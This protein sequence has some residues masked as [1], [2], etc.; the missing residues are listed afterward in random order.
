[1]KTRDDFVTNSSSQSYIVCI[2]NMEEFLKEIETFYEIPSNIRSC[3]KRQS[4]KEN[5]QFDEIPFEDFE[6]FNR[7]VNGSKYIISYLDSGPENFTQYINIANNKTKVE[8]IKKIL[9]EV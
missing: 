8:K 1:M 3:L 2:P 7:F 5:I 6:E 9:K 4:L